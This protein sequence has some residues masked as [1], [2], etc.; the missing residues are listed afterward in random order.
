VGHRDYDVIKD[1]TP[2][3]SISLPEI[4]TALSLIGKFLN[5]E[6]LKAK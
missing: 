4:D 1:L 5:G 3:P 6:C 2:L